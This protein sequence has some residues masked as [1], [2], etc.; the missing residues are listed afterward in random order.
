MTE[1]RTLLKTPLGDKPYLE[2][3]ISKLFPIWS[4]T[5]KKSVRF[6]SIPFLKTDSPKYCVRLSAFISNECPKSVRSGIMDGHTL[7][8][9]GVSYY[10]SDSLQIIRRLIC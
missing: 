2:M 10:L 8:F 5:V 7:P 6:L 3:A 4:R 9:R 1:K